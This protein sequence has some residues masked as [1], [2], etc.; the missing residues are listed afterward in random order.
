MSHSATLLIIVAAAIAFTVIIYNRMV[1]M[2]QAWKNALADIDVQLKQ[3]H[4]LIPNLVE[5]VKGYAAHES[6][7]FE[8][9]TAARASAMQA[10]SPAQKG[11]AE[12]ALSGALVN[13]MAVAENYPDLKAN[14][15]FKDLQ[16][17]L[18]DIENKIAAARRFY[19]NAVAEYNTAIAQFPAT[20]IAKNFGFVPGDMYALDAGERAEASQAPKVSFGS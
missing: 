17:E 8:K 7:V 3:R 13:L 12:A 16:D 14:Q 6:G 10:T 2:R 15:N 1:A 4:D 18:T 19:N 11:A 5:T 20:L 9:V